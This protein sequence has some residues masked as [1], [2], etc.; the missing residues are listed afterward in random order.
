MTP[1]IGWRA[2]ARYLAGESTPEEAANVDAWVQERPENAQILNSAQTAWTSAEGKPQSFDADRA[3]SKVAPRVTVRRKWRAEIWVPTLIAASMAFLF[4]LPRATHDSK[5]AAAQYATSDGQ[6]QT[7]KLPDGSVIRLAPNSRL[8]TTPNSTRE[9]WLE[10]TGFFAIAKQSGQK[11][12]VHT[13]SGDA[14][15]LGTRFELSSAGRAVRLVVFEGSVALSA[16][17]A[18]EVIDAGHASRVE[19]GGVPAAAVAVPTDRIS[20]WMNGVLIFQT[21]P[22]RD[23]AREIEQQYGVRVVLADE[24]LEH[25]TISAVF[26]HQ[27][28]ETVMTAVCRVVD[29]TCDIRDSEV[30]IHP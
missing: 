11:F 4:I 7:V 6:T 8:R 23:A 24:A 13:R 10:G 21:T 15:V 22:L 26:E 12:V 18:R 2:L 16:Q 20:D 30:S 27:S 29:A 3:W 5:D 9:V 17:G 28:L 1:R 19:D 14:Q 25:R